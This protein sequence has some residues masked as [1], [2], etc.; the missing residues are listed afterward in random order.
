MDLHA[1]D[2]QVPGGVPGV[3]EFVPNVDPKVHEVVKEVR[4]QHEGPLVQGVTA[5]PPVEV[6]AAVQRRQEP[7][8]E[9]VWQEVTHRLRP[10]PPRPSAGR[11]GGP[12]P[13]PTSPSP[14]P[15]PIALG[16]LRLRGL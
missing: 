2:E 1:P 7:V 16:S 5:V 4:R 15:S 3:Q 13:S 6:P 11:A 8:L 14:G 10:P 9:V 12:T